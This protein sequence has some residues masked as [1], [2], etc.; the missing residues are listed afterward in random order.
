M[1]LQIGSNR[2]GSGVS[3]FA[4]SRGRGVSIPKV[5]GALAP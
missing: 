3:G 2:S 5:V 1:S 4:K